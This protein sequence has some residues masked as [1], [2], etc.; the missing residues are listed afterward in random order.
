[1]KIWVENVENWLKNDKNDWKCYK[2]MW[3]YVY[4]GYI[5]W[6]NKNWTSVY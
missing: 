4:H 2:M 5:A 1:M 6:N 3:K